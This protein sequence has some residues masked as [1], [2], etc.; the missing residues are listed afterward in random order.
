V[1]AISAGDV[2]RFEPD[3]EHWH[4]ASPSHLMTHIA[5]QEADDEGIPAHWGEHVSDEEYR[6][7]PGAG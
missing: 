3:E 2:V 7:E 1:E 5:I 6:A 4:G